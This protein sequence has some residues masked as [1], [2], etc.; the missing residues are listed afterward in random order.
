M[1]DPRWKVPIHAALND[2]VAPAAY[3]GAPWSVTLAACILLQRDLGD[4]SSWAPYVRSLPTETIG[5]ANS[6]EAAA[7][8]AKSAARVVHSPHTGF[9]ST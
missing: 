5:F 8:S 4:A 2:G 7:E 9:H 1:E 3:P 6:D